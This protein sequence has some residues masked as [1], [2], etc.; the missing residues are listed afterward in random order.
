[1]FISDNYFFSDFNLTMISHY[2][3]QLNRIE[4][5]GSIHFINPGKEKVKS[6][7][8]GKLYVNNKEMVNIY[9]DGFCIDNFVDQ[10][11][12]FSAI[13]A[14]VCFPFVPSLN[15]TSNNIQVKKVKLLFVY[16][17]LTFVLIFTYNFTRKK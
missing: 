1:L 12:N 15:L 16:F 8:G 3:P 7:M 14:F 2:G 6:L 9:D 17:A 13:S 5:N 10:L 4:C 11:E